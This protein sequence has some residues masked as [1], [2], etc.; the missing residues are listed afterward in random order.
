MP[1]V[2]QCNHVLFYYCEI[3]IKAS[4]IL[5]Y[6]VAR[7]DSPV[8]TVPCLSY[9]MLTARK[10]SCGK[11]MFLHLTVILFIGGVSPPGR[12]VSVLGGSYSRGSLFRRVS[13][14]GQGVSVQGEGISVTETLPPHGGRVGGTHPTGMH[15]CN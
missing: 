6:S 12:G 13:V 9:C 8:Q 1:I 4:F 15:S 3:L 14:R 10:R 5:F 11:V 7:N 2:D